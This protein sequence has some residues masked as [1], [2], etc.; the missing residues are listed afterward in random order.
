MTVPELPSPDAKGTHAVDRRL[1]LRHPDGWRTRANGEAAGTQ[2]IK[3]RPAVRQI[4]NRSSGAGDRHRDGQHENTF[5]GYRRPAIYPLLLADQLIWTYSPTGGLVADPCCG[6]GTTLVAAKNGRRNWW[7]CDVVGKSVELSPRRLSG[8]LAKPR[9]KAGAFTL[10]HWVFILA[11]GLY[12]S[13]QHRSSC[14]VDFIHWP[15]EATDKDHLQ[16]ADCSVTAAM[17]SNRDIVGDSVVPPPYSNSG[18]LAG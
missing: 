13:F 1:C 7:G 12:V 2:A 15:H 3:Q 11:G 8:P 17:F 16:W 5:I 6:S 18:Q 14:R 10:A 9:M 4:Q